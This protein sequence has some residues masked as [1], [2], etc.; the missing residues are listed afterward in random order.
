[1]HIE[2]VSRIGYKVE[3]RPHG[4]FLGRGRVW[5]DTLVKIEQYAFQSS[6]PAESLVFACQMAA[7]LETKL[8]RTGR[9]V[10][11]L[12]IEFRPA[13]R[14]NEDWGLVMEVQI[15]LSNPLKMEEDIKV[16]GTRVLRGALGASREVPGFCTA[17]IPVE[18]IADRLVEQISQ[19]LRT[20]TERYAGVAQGW[21][22]ALEEIKA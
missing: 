7:A 1:M 19:A 9:L 5:E 17:R 14:Q 15:T 12:G 3:N 2:I 16:Q 20:E 22:E 10:K 21:Q 8:L 13:L 6:V 11:S 4:G 18:T